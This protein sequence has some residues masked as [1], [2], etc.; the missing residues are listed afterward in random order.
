MSL[1][2][3]IVARATGVKHRPESSVVHSP[4]DRAAHQASTAEGRTEY[5]GATEAEVRDHLDATR[6]ASALATVDAAM[7]SWPGN[8]RLG[9]LRGMVLQ[10]WGRSIEARDAFLAV[11]D[12]ENAEPELRQRTTMAL[13]QSGRFT[14]AEG[15]ARSAVL[16]G[17]DDPGAHLLLGILLQATGRTADA[18]VEFERVLALNPDDLDALRYLGWCRLALDDFAATDELLSIATA[19]DARRPALWVTLGT[20]KYRQRDL[21]AAIECFEKASMLELEGADSAGGCADL[22]LAL[23]DESRFEEIFALCARALP[24]QPSVQLHL[25]LGLALLTAGRFAEGWPLFEARFFKEPM[26]SRRRSFPRPL[27]R[28]Q[29]LT[30]KTILLAQEQGVGDLIQC[31][32]YASELKVAGARVLLAPLAGLEGFC[33]GLDGVDEVV[34]PGPLPHF[35]YYCHLMSLPGLFHA[36]E[37]TEPARVPYLRVDDGRLAHWR[38][39][40]PAGGELKVGLVWAG[41][42][43][44]GKDRERSIGLSQLAPLWSVSGALFYSLQK[45]S[46]AAEI[47]TVSAAQPMVDLGGDLND[48]AD[49][50]AA[51]ACL[52]LVISVDT[53]VA[54]LAGALGKPVWT[55]LP[56]AADWRWGRTS[57]VTPWY[58]SMRLFRQST[59]FQWADV[60][61]AVRDALRA[62]VRD[63]STMVSAPVGEAGL[64]DVASWRGMTSPALPWCAGA[65]C[66]TQS[67]HGL[68]QYLPGEDNE[69]DAIGW[70]GDYL[71]AVLASVSPL[72]RPGQTIVEIG[73]GIGSHAIPLAHEIS[74]DGHLFA[75]EDRERVRSALRQNLEANRVSNVTVLSLA[76]SASTHPP[77]T[78]SPSIS[79]DEL[80]LMSLH[81]LKLNSGTNAAAVLAGASQTLWRLRAPTLVVAATA[82]EIA[83]AGAALFETSYQCWTHEIPLFDEQNFNRR[84]N[85]IFGSRTLRVLLGMAEEAAAGMSLDGWTA[86]S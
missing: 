10:A 82:T 34:G 32:R 81:L 69:S 3:K 77:S 51:I 49:T 31:V 17:P 40:L 27:W 85:D 28:G 44:H 6:Y 36:Q 22:T 30:G 74:A 52:D 5:F 63:R 79:I 55:L 39:K 80:G 56:R 42:P 13:L 62:S 61:D 46:R 15:W 12:P 2:K 45:G 47:A 48:Y 35:D 26:L 50:A 41:N 64:A 33:R 18:A 20:S 23:M 21:N 57:D 16:R 38:S 65:S 83:A 4:L 9:F 75:I 78:H 7:R 66:F 43:E 11:A 71:E 86:L 8:P 29:D 25:S 58:P 84:G 67:R 19:L 59:H 73:S 68:F 24:V 60:I 53:S 1:F 14:E 37:A 54:H 70:Y 72:L 76:N